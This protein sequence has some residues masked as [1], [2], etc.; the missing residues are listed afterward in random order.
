MLEKLNPDSIVTPFNN[1]Y[2]HAVVIAPN[3]RTSI[4]PDKW[5]C[6]KTVPCPIL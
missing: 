5:A 6:A 2:H 3:S 1:A 4:S